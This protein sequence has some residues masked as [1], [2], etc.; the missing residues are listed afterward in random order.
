MTEGDPSRV[1]YKRRSFLISAA[2]VVV[3][4]VIVVTDLPESASLQSQFASD[5]STLQEV[6]SDLE[7][8]AFAA[9]ESFQI[10]GDQ[11]S[12]TLTASD[13]SRVPGLLRDDQTACSFASEP[14]YDLAS[15]IEPG[16]T[17]ARPLDQMI[18][19]VTLWATSDALSAIEAIQDLSS[20]PGDTSALGQLHKA[21]VQ[22]ANDRATAEAQLDQADH[23]LKAKLPRL[24]LPAFPDPRPKG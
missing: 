20:D 5:K 2:V 13:R 22:L 6:N 17:A 15:D 16:T 7:A 9:H 3:A 1:F 23:I 21:E 11:T 24:D 14:I 10:Y 12:H 8:C 18:G 19:T 4:A